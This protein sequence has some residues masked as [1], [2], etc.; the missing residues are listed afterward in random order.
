VV[1]LSQVTKPEIQMRVLENLRQADEDLAAA[2]ASGLGLE[3]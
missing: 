2:V 1:D 3:I